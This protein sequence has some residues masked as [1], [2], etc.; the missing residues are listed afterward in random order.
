MSSLFANDDDDFLNSGFMSQEEQEEVLEYGEEMMTIANLD[1]DKYFLET[2][3]IRGDTNFD[4]SDAISIK[5]CA[6]THS[7]NTSSNVINYSPINNYNTH[8]SSNIQYHTSPNTY[9]HYNQ[10]RQHFISNRYES[11]LSK[12]NEASF[13]LSDSCFLCTTN[14]MGDDDESNE[15]STDCELIDAHYLQV[16]SITEFT[17]KNSIESASLSFSPPPPPATPTTLSTINSIDIRLVPNNIEQEESSSSVF[18]RNESGRVS[19]KSIYSY[20][21]KPIKNKFKIGCNGI[22]SSNSR[23]TKQPNKN[24]KTKE[25]EQLQLQQQVPMPKPIFQCAKSNNTK[26]NLKHNHRVQQQQ[27]QQQPQPY[28]ISPICLNEPVYASISSKYE[29]VF[30]D[31]NNLNPN[32]SLALADKFHNCGDLVYYLV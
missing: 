4:E 29:T 2:T 21:I 32:E 19:C 18:K 30:V 17:S 20:L 1:I 8:D 14:T 26:L 13:D 28:F 27:Q 31:K 12:I 16:S 6:Y 5:R 22:S 25:N 9:N 15:N 11:P 24:F 7:H 3:V 23:K 10:H